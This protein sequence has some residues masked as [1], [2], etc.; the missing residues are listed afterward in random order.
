MVAQIDVFAYS[1]TI[2]YTDVFKQMNVFK[3]FARSSRH[4]LTISGVVLSRDV[5]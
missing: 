3:R 4:F 1:D 2:S 5:G